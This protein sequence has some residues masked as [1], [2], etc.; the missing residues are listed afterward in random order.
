MWYIIV[1]SAIVIL[2]LFINSRNKKKN[3]YS[4][5]LSDLVDSCSLYIE[6]IKQVDECDFEGLLYIHQ[7]GYEVG[8]T[9][10]SLSFNANGRFRKEISKLELS[11]IYLKD[12]KPIT[13]YLSSPE[14]SKELWYKYK[15]ILI[16]SIGSYKQELLL[17]IKE[18]L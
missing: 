5:D 2:T 17:R 12:D 3:N 9:P 16:G 4:E 13:Y 7:N 18:E 10:K 6:C 8:I 15:D 14:E 1:L 11:D